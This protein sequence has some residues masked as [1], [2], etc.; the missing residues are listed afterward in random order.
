ME[1]FFHPPPV[2]KFELLGRS[3]GSGHPHAQS[4]PWW[5]G[6]ASQILSELVFLPWICGDGGTGVR[7]DF[8]H[9]ETTHSW[10]GKC[11]SSA[12]HPAAGCAT[13]RACPWPEGE[14]GWA[15]V[16]CWALSL[17][18]PELQARGRVP[19]EPPGEE[20]LLILLMA[21][22]TVEM[23]RIGLGRVRVS[24]PR[25][26]RDKAE[27]FKAFCVQRMDQG[28]PSALSWMSRTARIIN[29][30]SLCQIWC[31]SWI[32]PNPCETWE[33]PNPCGTCRIHL[34]ILQEL[35]MPSQSLS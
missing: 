21:R 27:L 34:R 3:W 4:S 7:R 13:G 18:T 25:G 23:A 29:S 14:S 6:G 5:A 28:G 24:P 1:C 12:S 16:E 30:L 31:S 19:G 35:L 15:Q 26:D 10:L 20:C 11:F 8:R 17:L 32:P 22:G 9:L 33:P 2:A